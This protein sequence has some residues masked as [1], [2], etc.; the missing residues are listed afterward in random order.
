MTLR[1]RR[2]EPCEAPEFQG[3]LCGLLRSERKAVA[4]ICPLAVG[5]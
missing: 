2:A 4:L 5:L 3:G 1:L